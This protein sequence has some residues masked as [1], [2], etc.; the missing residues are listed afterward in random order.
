MRFDRR[1]PMILEATHTHLYPGHRGRI[2]DVARIGDIE[3]NRD[4]VVEFAD[5]SAAAAT[6]SQSAKDWRLRVGAYR[7]AAGTEIPAKNWLMRVDED[8]DRLKFRILAKAQGD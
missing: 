5:G 6:I 2:S 7:T 4:C 1:I 3:A 8:G